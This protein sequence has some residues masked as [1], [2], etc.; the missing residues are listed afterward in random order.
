VIRGSR[1][2]AK[3]N[4]APALLGKLDEPREHDLVFPEENRFVAA[5]DT[6]TAGFRCGSTNVYTEGRS[7]SGLSSST[8]LLL[9]NTEVTVMCRRIATERRLALGL[10]MSLMF[11]LLNSG[12]GADPSMPKLG[13]VTGKVTYK[14]EPLKG[15]SVTFTPDAAKGGATGQNALGQIESDGSYE[16]TTFNTGDGAILGQ[17]VVTVQA[18]ADTDAFKPK[19]DGTYSYKLPKP[20]IPLKYT[21]SDSTPL[22]LTVT[23][24]VNKLDI[25]LKD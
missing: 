8:L 15:G 3:W 10:C 14:G 12:C 23:E 16:L 21:K 6:L 7:N 1:R 13:K 9:D 18:Y 19:A 17:H 4:V 22:R 24:G 2:Q 11:P 25:E 5:D 20:T